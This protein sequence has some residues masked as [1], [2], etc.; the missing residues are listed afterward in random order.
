MKPGGTSTVTRM[1]VD[2]VKAHGR[3]HVE[4][5]LPVMVTVNG[6]PNG[7]VLLAVSVSVLVLVAGFVLH[8]AVTPLGRPVAESDTAPVNPPWSVIVIWSP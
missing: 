5:E 1:L 8:A 6:P 4:I 2:A 3:P 7:A